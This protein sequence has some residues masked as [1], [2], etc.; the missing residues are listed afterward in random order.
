MEDVLIKRLF[1]FSVA[2]LVSILLVWFGAQFLSID[3]ATFSPTTL[4][5][6]GLIVTLGGIML[7]TLPDLKRNILPGMVLVAI[8]FYGC[9]RAAGTIQEPW[10]AR[11]LGAAAWMAALILLY[12]TWPTRSRRSAAAKTE[13]KT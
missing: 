3:H 12:I 13:K 6:F 11:V 7:L 9:A 4:L 5:V 1:Y 10:L 8:G 2:I